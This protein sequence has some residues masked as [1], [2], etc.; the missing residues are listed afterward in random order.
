VN[1][2]QLSEAYPVGQKVMPKRGTFWTGASRA[3]VVGYVWSSDRIPGQPQ[4]FLNIWDA[5][6]DLEIGKYSL[7]ELM[8]VL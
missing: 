3:R 4:W 2:E 7:D 1:I 5:D 8:V 6:E